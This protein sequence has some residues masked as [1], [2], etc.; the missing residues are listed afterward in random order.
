MGFREAVT[1][2][3]QD[4]FRFSGRARRPEFWWF[5]LFCAICSVSLSLTDAA[6]FGE[7]MLL[8]L[9]GLF[10]LLMFVPQLAVAWRR[11]HDTSRPGWFNLFPAILTGPLL[12]VALFFKGSLDPAHMAVLYIMSYAL[13]I[14][15]LI[16]LAFPTQVGP[17]R[18]GP[19]PAD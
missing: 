7:D 2:C 8:G 5:F 4:C 11:M 13:A 18:Y 15:V 1:V 9:S 16:L 3:I 17:N 19:E 14:I 12:I 10:A 6:I